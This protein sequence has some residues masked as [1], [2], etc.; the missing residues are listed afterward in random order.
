MAHRGLL[1]R[2]AG[3]GGL[4][5]RRPG[6][7]AEGD[8]AADLLRGSVPICALRNWEG[9]QGMPG[10]PAAL[11][12]AEALGVPTERLAEGVEDPAEEAPAEASPP[13]AGQ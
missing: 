10:I 13:P 11:P 7:F 9:D 8:D 2:S 12:L 5:D 4:L 1:R 3:R 6:Q